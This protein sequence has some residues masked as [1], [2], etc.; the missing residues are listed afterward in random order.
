MSP[1]NFVIEL[2]SNR[3]K[4]LI[5]T[6]YIESSRNRCCIRIHVVMDS[7]VLFTFDHLI[8]FYL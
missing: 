7:G 2:L 3:F 1:S 8:S 4:G 5:T 6:E